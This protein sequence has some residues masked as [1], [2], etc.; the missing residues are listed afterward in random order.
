MSCRAPEQELARSRRQKRGPWLDV[1]GTHPTQGALRQ[2]CES[3]RPLCR[4]PQVVRV[5]ARSESGP[6]RGR[7]CHPAW[8]RRS[9]APYLCPELAQVLHEVVSKR[10]VI[11]DYKDHGSHVVAGLQGPPSLGGAKA[12]PLQTS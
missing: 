9:G 12:P 3:R 2:T 5:L 6:E 11:I 1:P 10:V 7:R 8:P 4:R